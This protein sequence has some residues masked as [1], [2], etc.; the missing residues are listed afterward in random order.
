MST[1]RTV[2]RGPRWWGKQVPTR[3][4]WIWLAGV[5]ASWLALY[6]LVAA[7]LAAG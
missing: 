6:S 2:V 3:I 1:H 7:G 5:I 4:H